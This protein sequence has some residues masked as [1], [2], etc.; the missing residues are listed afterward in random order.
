MEYFIQIEHIKCHIILYFNLFHN[1]FYDNSYDKCYV[2]LYNNGQL[3]DFFKLV[4]RLFLE[5]FWENC[6]FGIFVTVFMCTFFK[7]K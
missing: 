4:F 2:Y 6:A 5:I 7:I 1:S 3:Q